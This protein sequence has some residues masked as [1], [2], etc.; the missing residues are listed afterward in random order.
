VLGQV[1]RAESVPAREDRLLSGASP[2][3]IRSPGGWLSRA[4]LVASLVLG[5]YEVISEAA[6]APRMMGLRAAR[7]FGPSDRGHG[8]YMSFSTGYPHGSGW[9]R[10][11]GVR[12]HVI[13]HTEHQMW[14]RSGV[15]LTVRPR[16]MIALDDAGWQPITGPRHRSRGG[17]EART[18][19]PRADFGSD[20]HARAQ[21]L[22]WRVVSL[23]AGSGPTE[24]G[25]FQPT[26]LPR[27]RWSRIRDRATVAWNRARHLSEHTWRKAQ[28][29]IESERNRDELHAAVVAEYRAS[30]IDADAFEQ[31]GSEI[32]SDGTSNLEP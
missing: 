27:G 3:A 31:P 4:R 19:P 2:D 6:R 32:D 16:V 30:A 1:G 29:R 15:V 5:W 25:L 23:L 26:E 8:V 28:A 9:E 21:R 24:I 12:C 18:P 13:R 14:D 17:L 10:A 20:P 7:V 22:R 11:V